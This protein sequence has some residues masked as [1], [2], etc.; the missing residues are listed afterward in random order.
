M[1]PAAA[2]QLGSDGWWNVPGT[3]LVFKVHSESRKGL[4]NPS[5]DGK[6]PGWL[7]LLGDQRVTVRQRV[8]GEVEC[9]ADEWRKE[10]EGRCNQEWHGITV[11]TKNHEHGEL[12][13]SLQCIS[14]S[15]PC[16]CP[17]R[18]R[19]SSFCTLYGGAPKS[20][21]MSRR[22]RGGEGLQGCDQAGWRPTEEQGEG[23]ELPSSS[24]VH[25]GRGQS[26]RP[27][28]TVS[29]MPDQDIV[30]PTPVP[31]GEEEEGQ[32]SGCGVRD[33][34]G[35]EGAGG[36]SSQSRTSQEGEGRGFVLHRREALQETL[37]E[38]N[39]QLL[40]GMTSLLGQAMTPIVQGQQALMEMSQ[41]AMMGQ[42]AMMQ[43]VQSSQAE[44]T[45][46]VLHLMKTPREAPEQ[47]WDKVDEE[48]QHR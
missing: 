46:A 30:H 5:Q 19:K 4:Y 45:Q 36:G 6:N 9:F 10:E 38:P 40:T 43:A 39:Q 34:G 41:Q 29:S 11:F 8:S 23:G 14:S 47:E 15:N 27:M 31:T 20:H 12:C 21:F 28:A 33:E 13:S 2:A 3:S 22:S 42:G 18:D 16:Q 25:R 17:P 37:I 48:A 44:L 7:E 26:I 24:G 1:C 32:A 35:P